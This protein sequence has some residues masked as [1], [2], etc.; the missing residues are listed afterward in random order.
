LLE[1][2]VRVVIFNFT[3][4]YAAATVICFIIQATIL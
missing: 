4:P 3:P 2:L 1:T